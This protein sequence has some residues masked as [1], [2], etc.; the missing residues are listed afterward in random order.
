MT[1]PKPEQVYDNPDAYWG[2]EPFAEHDSV[3]N[4]SRRILA[5]I[6]PPGMAPRLR[7]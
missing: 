1:T 3:E 5:C 6:P 4:R 2:L 7:A